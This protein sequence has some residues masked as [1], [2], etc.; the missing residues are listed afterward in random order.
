MFVL[1]LS[2]TDDNN[3][4]ERH[5]MSYDTKVTL[6]NMRNAA[7]NAKTKTERNAWVAAMFALIERNK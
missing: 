7:R 6:N 1:F 2:D 3:P 5:K 4:N